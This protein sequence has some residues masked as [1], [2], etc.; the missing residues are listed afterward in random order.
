MPTADRAKLLA[1]HTQIHRP[2]LSQTELD[3]LAD[4]LAR[5]DLATLRE[6]SGTVD[7]SKFWSLLNDKTRWL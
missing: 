3:T 6:G 1:R 2:S 5:A 7:P 4:L